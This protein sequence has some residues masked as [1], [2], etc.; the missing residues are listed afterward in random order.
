MLNDKCVLCG[1]ICLTAKDRYCCC[2]GSWGQHPICN[3]CMNKLDDGGMT[4][5]TFLGNKL[6]ICP[7]ENRKEILTALTLME[8]RHA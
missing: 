3:P 8:G 2:N 4:G 5:F 1:T 7:A 6:L